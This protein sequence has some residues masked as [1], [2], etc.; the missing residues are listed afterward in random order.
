MHKVAH[1]SN[2]RRER[3]NEFPAKLMTPIIAEASRFDSD[4]KV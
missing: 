1:A 3:E 4:T 2:R